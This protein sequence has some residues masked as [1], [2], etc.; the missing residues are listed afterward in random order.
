MTTLSKDGRNSF[1]GCIIGAFWF[2]LALNFKQMTLYYAPAVFF[3]LLGCCCAGTFRQF[4]TRFVALGLT[5]LA[6]FA[7]LW[8]PFVWYSPSYFEVSVTERLVHVLRRIFPFQRG[9][10]EG[11]VSN[12]W[13]ALS[14]KPI[15]IRKRIPESLQ[16]GLALGMTLILI[17]PACY[18]L[19]QVGRSPARQQGKTH[20]TADLDFRMLLWGTTSTGL[21]FF[22]ASF[23]VHEKSIL[24]ALSPASLL[25]WEDIEFINWFSIVCVWTIW[26]LM[27]VDRLE[28]AYVCTIVMFIALTMLFRE[29]VRTWKQSETNQK[30]FFQQF[31]VT[32]SIVPLS[33][34]IMLTLHV[35]EFTLS[36]PSRLPDLFPLLWSVAGCGMFCLAWLIT[37]WHLFFDTLEEQNRHNKVDK[38]D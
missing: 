26:P 33:V 13:C 34:L 27:R 15:S 25:L 30:S 19:F 14:A 12:L 29:N 17:L 31:T 21:A 2:C 24:M 6:T 37:C 8:W 35:L 1:F 18:K 9:L 10:F 38:L 11:K 3:Y 20:A 28:V 22:L 4:V 23:Q 5:V 16:P 7:T 36:V 32:R